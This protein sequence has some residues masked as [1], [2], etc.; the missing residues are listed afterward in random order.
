MWKAIKKFIRE[1][2]E[3]PDEGRQLLAK[4]S[5]SYLCY[6][7]TA[8]Q[9]EKQMERDNSE[10]KAKLR[11]IAE[12]EFV[13][14]SYWDVLFNLSNGNQL[15]I[16]TIDLST[17]AGRIYTSASDKYGR[18]MVDLNAVLLRATEVFVDTVDDLPSWCPAVKCEFGTYRTSP[19]WVKERANAND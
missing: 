10:K 14:F 11:E 4:E 7:Y 1:Y 19:Q 17:H 15:A 13:P 16:D 3:L 6:Y 9:K 18:I 2:K 5:L 8:W 12:R